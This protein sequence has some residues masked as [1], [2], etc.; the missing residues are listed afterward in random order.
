MNIQHLQLTLSF[1]ERDSLY[2]LYS[3][4][5]SIRCPHDYPFRPPKCQFLQKIFHPNVKVDTGEIC[6]NIINESENEWTPA[7]SLTQI[8]YG[9]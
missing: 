5:V 3:F 7:N 6:L 9:L 4:S 8:S 2:H 1:P